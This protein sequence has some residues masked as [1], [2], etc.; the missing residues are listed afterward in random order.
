MSQLFFIILFV[1]S[2]CFAVAVIIFAILWITNP[3]IAFY[4]Q[5]DNVLKP[6]CKHNWIDYCP[7]ICG[8]EEMCNKCVSACYKCKSVSGVY[9]SG[10]YKTK[11]NRHD[12]QMISIADLT[13][14]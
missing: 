3:S 2:A 14:S 8:N 9:V 5:Y 13:S 4:P 7:K 6:E 11:L 10:V 12:W 1:I